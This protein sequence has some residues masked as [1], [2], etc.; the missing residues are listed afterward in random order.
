VSRDT[1]VWLTDILEGCRRIAEYTVGMDAE[2]FRADQRTLDAVVRNLQIIGEAVKQLPDDV[3]SKER[4]SNGG[5]S[6]VFETSWCTH[7]SESTTRSFGTL[8][9][10]SCPTSLRRSGSCWL[11]QLADGAAYGAGSVV[12]AGTPCSRSTMRSK[13]QRL[14][15]CDWIGAE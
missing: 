3:R 15:S 14:P 6:L 5:K 11:C 1:R 9:A 2:T 10:P 12:V 4:P 8:S 7:T 13:Q